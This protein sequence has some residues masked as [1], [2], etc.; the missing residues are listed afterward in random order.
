MWICMLAACRRYCRHPSGCWVHLVVELAT[1]SPPPPSNCRGAPTPVGLR[2]VLAKSSGWSSGHPLNLVGQNCDSQLSS[3][4]CATEAHCGKVRTER[5]SAHSDPSLA[6]TLGACDWRRARTIE[7]R[8]GCYAGG[9]G[10]AIQ[11]SIPFRSYH[12]QFHKVCNLVWTNNMCSN[13]SEGFIAGVC[14][15]RSCA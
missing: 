3:F 7:L 5:T 2:E 14:C 11:G 12:L 13:N 6:P 15:P 1:M 8:I 10:V 4:Q 9:M